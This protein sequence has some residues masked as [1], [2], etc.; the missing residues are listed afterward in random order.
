MTVPTE[1]LNDLSEE[2]TQKATERQKERE[3]Q[4]APQPTAVPTSVGLDPVTSNFIN[5][6]IGQGV[7]GSQGETKGPEVMLTRDINGP[8]TYKGR[9]VYQSNPR[10]SKPNS[11]SKGD[12]LEQKVYRTE[13]VLKPGSIDEERRDY[14]EYSKGG[15]L[16][17][18][19]DRI[20]QG[21]VTAA[22]GDPEKYETVFQAAVA[23]A[24]Y[25]Q[26]A[27]PPGSIGSKTT[28]EDVLNGWIK[29]GL[30]DSLKGGGGGGGGGGPRAFTNIDTRVDL[31]NKGEARRIVNNALT[32]ALGRE[33]TGAETRAFM[34]AL[35]MNEEANPVVT[36]SKGVTSASGT[37]ST[38]TSEGGFD[39][40]DFAD[41]YAKSQEG[42]AEYQ[43]ATTY[44]D[45]FI[46]A[47]ESD[48]RII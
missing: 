29:N 12:Y 45:S 41:R 30:P 7:L 33:A 39:S 36:T 32:G 35:N 6:L 40:A 24:A 2:G 28:V 25:I 18:D 15:F 44:L 8:T 14:N 3:Q 19:N 27:S 10:V 13:E 46:N 20:N 17:N 48:S 26:K 4:A 31:T 34:K 9:E 22:G 47:L 23:Q 38:T 1:N 16:A 21:V 5:T 43:T 11:N 37:T 42:Y